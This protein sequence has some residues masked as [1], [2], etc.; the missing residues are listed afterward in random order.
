MN[1]EKNTMWYDYKIVD[2]S[3]ATSTIILKA[4]TRFTAYF[5]VKHNAC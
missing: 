5:N 2:S 3:I 1:V 4:K